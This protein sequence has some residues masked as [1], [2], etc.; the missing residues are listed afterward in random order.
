MKNY[1]Q[2]KKSN[3]RAGGVSGR[4]ILELRVKRT[5]ENLMEG[6]RHARSITVIMSTRRMERSI[7]S[8]LLGTLCT[9]ETSAAQRERGCRDSCFVD[10]ETEAQG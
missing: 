5:R 6:L 7:R 9:H 3:E 4:N 8:S 10:E 1:C 2:K